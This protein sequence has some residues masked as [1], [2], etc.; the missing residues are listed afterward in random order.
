MT[1]PPQQPGPWAWPPAQGKAIVQLLALDV[2]C[3]CFQSL[4]LLYFLCL[5]SLSPDITVLPVLP[6]V[7]RRA[8]PLSVLLGLSLPQLLC[9]T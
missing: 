3:F 2:S 9:V 6:H 7:L 1:P 8:W 4:C 5:G